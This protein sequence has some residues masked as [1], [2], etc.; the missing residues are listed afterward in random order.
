MADSAATTTD[1]KSVPKWA[2]GLLSAGFVVWF[3]MDIGVLRWLNPLWHWL[4]MLILM[5]ASLALI[6]YRVTNGRRLA[7]ALID[8][9]NRFSLSRLQIILWT[10]LALSAFATI[11][12]P[13]LLGPLDAATDEMKSQC[14]QR[15][16]DAAKTNGTTDQTVIDAL[17]SEQ[18]VPTPLNIT[19]PPE[20]LLAMGISATSF[21]GSTLVQSS[22]KSKQVN[23]A[24]RTSELDAASKAVEGAQAELSKAKIDLRNKS[25]NL[26][27][28]EA[29]LKEAESVVQE[30]GGK[31]PEAAQH[32]AQTALEA[33]VQ[34]LDQA[35]AALEAARQRR[36][37]AGEADEQAQAQR[38]LE[39]AQSQVQAARFAVD[40]ATQA[41][42]AAKAKVDELADAKNNVKMLQGFVNNAKDEVD[43]ATKQQTY[44]ENTLLPDAQQTLQTAQEK[45][46]KTE[47]LLHKNSSIA[48]ANWADLFRGEEVGN[49]ELT[50]VSKVQMFFFTVV[51]V[52]TYG[53]AI[54]QL[55]QSGSALRHPFWVD[56]PSFSSTLNALL[57]ISHGAYLSVK[58]VDH[59]KTN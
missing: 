26:T 13:R 7:G 18:C 14:R 48:D 33:K 11:A 42:E 20:L 17:V 35:V 8:A 55:L 37:Q 32:E 36:E 2:Y 6:G 50:D 29:Q 39:A 47:G 44:V 56:L 16:T 30:L 58:S 59:T 27:T 25:A 53:V 24:A 52:F 21:A 51:I 54:A 19:F 9:R 43:A 12:P 10:L 31:N 23:V 46:D 57:G 49:Y 15:V 28:L 22:K 45:Y 34:S 5:I 1:K 3:L 41:R 40:E 4:Y 38:E